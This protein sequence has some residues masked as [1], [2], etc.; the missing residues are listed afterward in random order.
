MTTEGKS[1]KAYIFPF[2]DSFHP[3]LYIRQS[4]AKNLDQAFFSWTSL[5]G[6]MSFTV[7]PQGVENPKQV[8]KDT[9]GV[10]PRCHVQCNQFQ[11][12]SYLNLFLLGC[13]WW[14][15]LFL[16]HKSQ[17]SRRRC[18]CVLCHHQA[19]DAVL[20]LRHESVSVIV[21]KRQEEDKE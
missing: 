4:E 20:L 18:H 17:R 2:L 11:W 5:D 10:T 19:S 12:I 6:N 1:C 15:S 14:W 21:V 8:D 3:F 7:F 16:I 13:W 9:V